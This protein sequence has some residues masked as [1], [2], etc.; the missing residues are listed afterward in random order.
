MSGILGP[1]R[2]RKAGDAKVH[3]YAAEAGHQWWIRL[4][5]FCCRSLGSKPWH[6]QGR[7]RIAAVEMFIVLCCAL[8]IN[9]IALE[10]F[11]D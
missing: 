2:A 3:C 9:R 5:R 11:P 4:R 7:A 8:E 6:F 1:R 10:V